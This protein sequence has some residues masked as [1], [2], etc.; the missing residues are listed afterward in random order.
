MSPPCDRSALTPSR[1]SAPTN[2][3]RAAAASGGEHTHTSRSVTGLPPPARPS[4]EVFAEASSSRLVPTVMPHA[5]R[6]SPPVACSSS[7]NRPPRISTECCGVATWICTP[8]G[9]SVSDRESRASTTRRSPG[10]PMA[11]A[12]AQV[13]CSPATAASAPSRARPTASRPRSSASSLGSAPGFHCTHTYFSRH[14]TAS[15]SHHLSSRAAMAGHSR[16]P[17][18]TLF[19]SVRSC[20]RLTSSGATAHKSKSA[21]WSAGCDSASRGHGWSP[22]AWRISHAA[23]T[24]SASTMVAGDGL[25]RPAVPKGGEVAEAFASAKGA[26]TTSKSETSWAVKP[27]VRG[28]ADGGARRCATP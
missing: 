22:K 26:A 10:T 11:T 23:R 2:S 7:S 24:T 5:T 25:L 16:R 28:L 12:A 19:S 1:H 13:A 21:A 20:T 6:R 17:L 3:I 18:A 27:M 14:W 4:A 9:N 15:A 8:D